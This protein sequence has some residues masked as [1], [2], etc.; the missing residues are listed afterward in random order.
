MWNVQTLDVLTIP[1]EETFRGTRRVIQMDP[2]IDSRY[3]AYVESQPNA[4]IYHHP[5][6]LQVLTRENGGQPLCLACEGSDGRLCGV[7]PLFETRGLP[8]GRGQLTGRRLSSLPRTPVGGPLASDREA[9]AALLRA[10]AERID[11]D[12]RIQLQIKMGSDELDGVVDGIAGARWRPAYVMEL[13]DRVEDL[14][15]GNSRNHSRIRS[16]INKANK[17]NLHLREADSEADLRAWYDVYLG[18]LRWHAIPPRSYRFFKAAWDVLRPRG[19]FRLLLAEVNESHETRLLAGSIFLMFGRTYFYAFTGC[20][21]GDLSL[22]ANDAIQWRAIHDACAAGFR[23]YD[24][25]EVPERHDGLAQFK[26]KWG[27]QEQWLYRYY[28]PV[29]PEFESGALESNWRANLIK[30]VWRRL[31]L[32]ATMAFGDTVYRYL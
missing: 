29:P 3:G 11:Q 26:G 23:Y 4:L 30:T 6:W 8:F 1:R 5:V 18:T 21:R 20:R 2:E 15:F 7:L 13:P 12:G 25:G 32:K 10:A 9:T 31:P 17:L 16:S 22:R 24:L 28:Y 27:A 19:F 14:R